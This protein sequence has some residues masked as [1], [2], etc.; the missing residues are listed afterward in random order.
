MRAHPREDGNGSDE[1]AAG[2]Q[3]SGEREGSRSPHSP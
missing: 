1:A 2:H 3:P